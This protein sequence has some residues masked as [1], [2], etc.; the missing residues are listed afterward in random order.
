MVLKELVTKSP[1]ALNHGWVLYW[2]NRILA[3]NADA[4]QWGGEPDPHANSNGD[5][6]HGDAHSHTHCRAR[7]RDAVGHK[8]QRTE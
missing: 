1:G 5:S 6:T 3:A 4:Q 7:K 2:L 8:D